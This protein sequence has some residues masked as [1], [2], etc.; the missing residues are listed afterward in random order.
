MIVLEVT[1]VASATT[2]G[3]KIG[4]P[5]QIRSTSGVDQNGPPADTAPHHAAATKTAAQ[6]PTATSFGSTSSCMCTNI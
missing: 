3:Q 4:N 6:P 5:Q 2:V 1:V